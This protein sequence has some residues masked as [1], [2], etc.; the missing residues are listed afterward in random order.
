MRGG[1]TRPEFQRNLRRARETPAASVVPRPA[2]NGLPVEPPSDSD[3]PGAAAEAALRC[4]QEYDVGGSTA[5]HW[6]VVGCARATLAVAEELRRN[7]EGLLS[8]AQKAALA[9][10][11]SSR[12]LEILTLIADGR[13]NEEIGKQVSL[14]PFT[15]RDHATSL[16]RKLHAKNRTEAVRLAQKFGLLG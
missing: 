7:R 4:A 1:K 10:P 9:P 5:L 11:L 15:V 3:P 12:E 2:G 8:N 14:S 16:F 13:T 6:A